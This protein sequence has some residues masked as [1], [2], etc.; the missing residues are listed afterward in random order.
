M[1]IV[2]YNAT[3]KNSGVTFGTVTL[4]FNRLLYVFYN[5][6]TLTLRVIKK[7]LRIGYHV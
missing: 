6:I 4:Y 1:S 5:T 7:Y 3:A 2:F